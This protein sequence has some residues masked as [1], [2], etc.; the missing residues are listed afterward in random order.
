MCNAPAARKFFKTR[1]HTRYKSSTGSQIREV[2]DGVRHHWNL[3]YFAFN[4][5]HRWTESASDSDQRQV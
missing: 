4:P 3:A 2:R 5:V 1:T